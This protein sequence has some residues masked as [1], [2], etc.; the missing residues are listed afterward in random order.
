MRLFQIAHSYTDQALGRV[1]EWWRSGV[2]RAEGWLG[3]LWESELLFVIAIQ[4]AP[5]VPAALTAAR[6]NGDG[7]H[8]ARLSCFHQ[9]VSKSA[10]G[11]GG[12]HISQRDPTEAEYKNSL[13]K[14]R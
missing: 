8:S 9:V 4:N 5:V 10:A 11:G 1:G 14:P 6:R 13:A 12:C 2:R 7:A 3:C